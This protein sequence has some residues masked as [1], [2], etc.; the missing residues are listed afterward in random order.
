ME[1]LLF[2]FDFNNEEIQVTIPSTLLLINDLI[3][4]YLD[5]KGS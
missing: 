3:L 1:E 4:H 2:S 5:L